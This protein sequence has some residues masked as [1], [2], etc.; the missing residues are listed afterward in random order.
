[1]SIPSNISSLRKTYKPL[2]GE[3]MAANAIISLC[4]EVETLVD[5]LESVWSYYHPT[6]HR[7]VDGIDML[8]EVYYELLSRGI[9]QPTGKDLPIRVDGNE[10]LQEG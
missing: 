2:Q 7:R 10:T 3:N 6:A 9:I 4:N 5:I 1:M 8:D